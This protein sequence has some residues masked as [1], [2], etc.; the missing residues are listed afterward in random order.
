ME[1][2]VLLRIRISHFLLYLR[3]LMST[4]PILAGE[5]KSL[6]D[7][8]RALIC[9]IYVSYDSVW[10]FILAILANNPCISLKN[11]SCENTIVL[12]TSDNAFPTLPEKPAGDTDFSDGKKDNSLERTIGKI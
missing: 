11:L 4:Y 8:T 6:L 7:F 3:S 1:A 9:E 2:A 5:Y 12:F 10:I